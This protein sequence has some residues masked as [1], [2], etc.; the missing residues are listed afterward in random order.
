V[1]TLLD[2]QS[3]DSA[4]TSLAGLLRTKKR[5]L[6]TA[7]TSFSPEEFEASLEH[8]DHPPGT[9]LW[10]RIIGP[11]TSAPIPDVVHWFHATRVPPGTDF[12]EGI[13]PLGARL[14]AIESLVATLA[15]MG[16]PLSAA[17]AESSF[18]YRLKAPDPRF[19]EP[20]GFLVRDAIVHPDSATH[21]YLATPEIIEDLAQ[22]YGPGVEMP[23][24]D[25][26][27]ASTKPCIVKFRSTEP[28]KYVVEVALFYCHAT[29][30]VQ[31]Q[32]LETNTCFDGKAKAVPFSDIIAIEYPDVD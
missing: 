28:R 16:S 8:A 17:Q 9:V 2:C 23:I 25:K 14:P 26:F 24:I 19:W 31:G 11:R 4:L 12:S 1:A 3:L 30:W 7:L 27:R 22:A 10:N 20:Y 5:E 32:G 6:R 21:N 15:E 29:L 18:Q 13:Q